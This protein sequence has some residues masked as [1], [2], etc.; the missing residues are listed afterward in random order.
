MKKQFKKITAKITDWVRVAPT[1]K[2]QQNA[3]VP[4]PPKKIT[5]NDLHTLSLPVPVFPATTPDELFK[6][7]TDQILKIRNILGLSIEETQ[8]LLD[9]VLLRYI[10]LVHLL[11]ASEVHHH[12][13]IGG[14]LRHGLEVAY[15]SG[16]HALAYTFDFQGKLK[17]KRQHALR[18]R[19]AFV[20]GGLLHDLGKTVS[21]MVVTDSSGQHVW[22]PFNDSV[23]EWSQRLNITGYYVFWRKNRI[24]KQHENNGL[25]LANRVIGAEVLTYLSQYDQDLLQVLFSLLSGHPDRENSLYKAVSN[26]DSHSTKKDLEKNGVPI[27]TYLQGSPLD[28]RLVEIMRELS[29]TTWTVNTPGAVVWHLPNGLFLHWGKAV[30]D[31]NRMVSSMG[32]VGIPK[33]E[34][35]LADTLID[36]GV[37][38]AYVAASMD[39][40]EEKRYRYHPLLVKGKN[41][42]EKTELEK[43]NKSHDDFY[44]Y[45]LLITDFSYVFNGPCPPVLATPIVVTAKQAPVEPKESK[46][47]TTTEQKKNDIKQPDKSTDKPP[48]PIEIKE[49]AAPIIQ[50]TP[51]LLDELISEL[52]AHQGEPPPLEENPTLEVNAE[53]ES[54]DKKLLDKPL[55][56]VETSSKSNEAS[57]PTVGLLLPSSFKKTEEVSSVKQD[58]NTTPTANALILPSKPTSSHKKVEPKQVDNEVQSVLTLPKSPKVEPK[59]KPKSKSKAKVESSKATDTTDSHK[60]RDGFIEQYISELT[61]KTTKSAAELLSKITLPILE[62]ESYLGSELIF[63]QRH[64]HICYP[65]GIKQFG[66][67]DEIVS[68]LAQDSVIEANDLGENIHDINGQL[69]L[70]LTDSLSKFIKE[71]LEDMASQVDPVAHDEPPQLPTGQRPDH[72]GI[73]T[74][75]GASHNVKNE[76]TPAAA[77]EPMPEPEIETPPDSFYENDLASIEQYDGIFL[78]NSEVYASPP[79]TTALEPS[80][81]SP[82]PERET[83][84]KVEA[85][86]D[87]VRVSSDITNESEDAQSHPIKLEAFDP[88]V[89]ISRLAAMIVAGEGEWL[90]GGVRRVGNELFTDDACLDAIVKTYPNTTKEQMKKYIFFNRRTPRLSAQEGEIILVKPD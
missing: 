8:E 79:P 67:P 39:T 37:A 58:V 13:D 43:I 34:G 24:H 23:W 35:V 60:E 10:E 29:K 28:L 2:N 89:V 46:P 69:V 4:L 30:E 9:P 80:Y 14:L 22:Q 48:I 50:E 72:L 38:K 85:I 57:T 16:Q 44:I 61:M 6:Q 20:L 55:E 87:G 32:F 88:A 33:D 62:Q 71:K 86:E 21:D 36:S 18:W 5:G 54:I 70:R 66:D 81:I 84:E 53:A 45:G 64:L 78:D 56:K 49:E 47:K 82:E 77:F 12:R 65:E 31:I 19:L 76:K 11:P 75:V 73:T 27:N 15:W 68:L 26:A 41:E 17:D 3:P 40:G 51:L 42:D 25:P 90:H 52:V 83:I 59:P 63:I 7:Y 74:Q 1:R